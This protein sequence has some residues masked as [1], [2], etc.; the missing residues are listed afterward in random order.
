M[1][2]P[3][4]LLF[5]A[6][7]T[8]MDTYGIIL[9]SMRYTVNDV[10]GKD[11]SNEEL[12]R[13]VGTPLQ[14]QM[15]YF[16]DGD[17]AKAEELVRIYRQHNDA[18][19]DQGVSAFPDTATALERFHAVGYRMGVVTSK[20][21]KMAELGLRLCGILDYFEFVIGSD[22][23]PEHKP[24]PGPIL[25]ACDLMGISAED[26][27]YIGD[28]PYDIQAGNGAGCTTVAALWGMFPEDV[29]M[30]QHPDMACTSL[31][32]LADALQYET[33]GRS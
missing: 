13:G 32:Q 4:A 1:Q 8:L 25:H 30:A 16:A 3:K 22:D 12:M 28:S 10:F 31:S 19:H 7:G 2:R 24:E 9:M 15:T 11:V 33:E 26:S 6:D 27:M 21:H 23:W 29:L 18:I 5:D 20:R 14:D 17:E